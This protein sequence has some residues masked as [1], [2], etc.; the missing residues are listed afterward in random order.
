MNKDGYAVHPLGEGTAITRIPDDRS[1]LLFTPEGRHGKLTKRKAVGLLTCKRMA[2]SRP[3]TIRTITKEGFTV[4]WQDPKTSNTTWLK[5]AAELAAKTEVVASAS[6]AGA[7]DTVEAAGVI[8][9]RP[10]DGGFLDA[11]VVFD[12]ISSRL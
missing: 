12:Q 1:L 7:A 10:D 9:L 6:E 4:L 11:D 5:N 8:V 3:S 2:A